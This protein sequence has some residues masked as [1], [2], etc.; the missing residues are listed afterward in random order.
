M[1]HSK[2]NGKENTEE[3]S[4]NCNMKKVKWWSKE[5][6]RIQN[7]KKLMAFMVIEYSP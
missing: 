4:Y 7:K 3:R 6:I 1:D 5:F 2:G